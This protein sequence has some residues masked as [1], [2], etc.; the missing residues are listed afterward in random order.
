MHRII[1]FCLLFL[2]LLQNGLWA[3]KLPY[4]KP[5]VQISYGFPEF[6][7]HNTDKLQLD[8]LYKVSVG[9]KRLQFTKEDSR[10]R[11]ADYAEPFLFGS[12]APETKSSE[13]NTSFWNVGFGSRD[14]YAYQFQ[15]S[16]LT[17]F[18]KS[19]Y[20]WSQT[21]IT[22]DT[23][24]EGY[25]RFTS[26]LK[27]GKSVGTGLD[28]HFMDRYS[29]GVGFEENHLFA[30]YLFPKSFTASFIQ[31]ALHKLS[32]RVFHPVISSNAMLFPVLHVL[33]HNAINFGLYELRQKNMYWPLKS[34]APLVIRSAQVRFS[35][36]F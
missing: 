22:S 26:G 35:L 20:T 34:E 28:Y 17:L 29:L 6:S 15:N 30:A 3:Q 7:V 2:G 27:F 21:N 4:K 1:I 18:V 5:N 11:I 14:G 23:I 31:F 33:M 16:S 13:T 24:P 25:Q 10:R 36:F 8:A 9:L 19:S 32:N 12:F